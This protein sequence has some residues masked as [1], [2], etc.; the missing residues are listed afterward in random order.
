MSEPTVPAQLDTILSALGSM[1]GR[2][3]IGDRRM[4]EA[5]V[6]R[7][8][9]NDKLDVQGLMLSEQSGHLTEQDDKLHAIGKSVEK[10]VEAMEAN[11]AITTTVKE[12]LIAARVG[13]TVLIW[14]C[15][16]VGTVATCAGAVYGAGKA[17][18]WF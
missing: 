7:G 12:A 5:D 1:Q 8:Q 13:R 4:N 3:E 15:S 10:L 17:F 11:T 2:L 16:V 18:G 14:V 6:A 9:M